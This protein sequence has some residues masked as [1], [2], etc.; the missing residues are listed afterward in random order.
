MQVIFS[1]TCIPWWDIT[2]QQKFK[3]GHH[4]K[5]IF[6]VIVVVISL[7]PDN[8][9]LL[10]KIILSSRFTGKNLDAVTVV[11]DSFKMADAFAGDRT[12]GAVAQTSDQT[13][14]ISVRQ[15]RVWVNRLQRMYGSGWWVILRAKSAIVDPRDAAVTARG[16]CSISLVKPNKDSVTAEIPAACNLWNRILFF[17]ARDSE[18]CISKVPD[19]SDGCF[20]WS[21]EIRSRYPQYHDMLL[22]AKIFNFG[23]YVRLTVCLSVCLF[24]CLSGLRLLAGYRSRHLTNHHQTWPK[25]VSW[26]S[27]ETHLLSRSKVK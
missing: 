7:S 15:S 5:N 24:V 9:I 16:W 21:G 6:I 2:E 3:M 13:V 14:D 8:L 18:R 20:P 27:L 22:L 12:A 23:K 11:T 1:T 26:S 25:C 10:N 17:R 4:F 19:D